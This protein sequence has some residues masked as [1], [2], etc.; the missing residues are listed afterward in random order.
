VG[1]IDVT[2]EGGWDGWYWLERE[3]EM[4]TPLYFS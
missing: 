3:G 4:E 2:G 1:W